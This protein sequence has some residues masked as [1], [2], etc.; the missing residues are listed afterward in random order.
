M[1]LRPLLAAKIDDEQQLH[2]L[3]YPLLISPKLDG[4]RLRIDP[5][6]G[7]V[8]RTHKPIPNAHL[9]QIIKKHINWLKYLD[10]EI[11]IG[12]PTAA[13]VFNKTQSAVMTRTGNPSFAYYVFDHWFDNRT[14]YSGRLA[15]VEEVIKRHGHNLSSEEG[16]IHI[17]P[18][19]AVICVSD[20]LKL[21]EE[22]VEEGFEGIILRN[23][24]APYK[25]GRSTFKE[26][27]L[28]KFKRVEDGEAVIV[29]FEALERNNNVQTRDAFGLAKRSSHQE[30]R[31]AVELLG[32]LIV[33]H[34]TFGRFSIGSGFDVD[35]RDEIWRNQVHYLGK[36]ITFKYQLV[37]IKDKPRFPIFKGFRH[38]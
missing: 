10:G 14:P 37:G 5:E 22:Y 20:V 18:Q 15:I 28:L 17:V 25:N 1:S 33:E 13:D 32:N 38:D 4:I 31:V 34:P 36:T 2:N 24:N 27:T 3:Q 11:I 19:R 30:G 35:T 26:Q 21:E 9:Q 8:S 16:T 7:G 23:P 29:G 6:L 12:D